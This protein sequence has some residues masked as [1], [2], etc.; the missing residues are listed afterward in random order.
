MAYIIR[1]KIL[2]NALSSSVKTISETFLNC[3]SL[4]KSFAN[5]Y[6]KYRKLI[7]EISRISYNQYILFKITAAPSH[8]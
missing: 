7:Q 4:K 6:N 3:S 1:Y 8:T 2:I 5:N